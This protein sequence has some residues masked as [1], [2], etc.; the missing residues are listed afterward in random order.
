MCP[1]SGNETWDAQESKLFDDVIQSIDTVYSIHDI[2]SM[3]P[4]GSHRL[5][6]NELIDIFCFRSF[7]EMYNSV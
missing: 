5:A 7:I 2:T 3:T 6:G 4:V 1:G